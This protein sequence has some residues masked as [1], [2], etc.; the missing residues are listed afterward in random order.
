MALKYIDDVTLKYFWGRL[1]TYFVK[2]VDGKGLSTN[3]LTN[4]LKSN[5][6]DAVTKA[7]ALTTAGAEANKINTIKV[8][9]V[10]RK[11]DSSKTVDIPVPTKVSALDNDMEYQTPTSVSLRIATALEQASDQASELFVHQEDGKGLSTNDLTNDL[12]TA[13]DNAVATVNGIVAS[14]GFD[15]LSVYPVGSIYLSVNSTNPSELFGGTWQSIGSGRVLQGAD[16]T[17]AAGS[18]IEAGL[19]NIEKEIPLYYGD[20][21]PTADFAPGFCVAMDSMTRIPFDFPIDASKSSPVYGRSDTVQ[22][23]AFVVNIWVRTA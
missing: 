11:P 6:D 9:G 4:E 3:D 23:P 14:G 21:S 17:H 18:T 15:P 2:A 16:D 13:Y 8:N 10:E 1:K 7:N 12:K 20:I 19:P 22:P 5:Y